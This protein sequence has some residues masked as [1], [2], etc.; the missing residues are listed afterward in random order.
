MAGGKS[1]LGADLRNANLRSAN[2]SVANLSVANLSYANLSGANLSDARNLTS[3][4]LDRACGKPTRLPEGKS[5]NLD[6]PCPPH[7]ARPAQP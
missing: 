4:Q 1:S 3:E 6:K 7:K 5:L 2:L